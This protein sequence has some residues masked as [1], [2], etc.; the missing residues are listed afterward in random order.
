[1]NNPYS[2]K[3]IMDK[4]G[5]VENVVIV[6]AIWIGILSIIVVYHIL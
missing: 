2:I 4:I 5:R 6:L 1:M 3:E